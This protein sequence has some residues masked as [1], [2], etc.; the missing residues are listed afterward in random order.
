MII[1]FNY[2]YAFVTNLTMTIIK[3]V[4]TAN[5]IAN[6]TIFLKNDKIIPIIKTTIE[7]IAPDGKFEKNFHIIL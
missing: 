2:I 3:I 4:N 5:Q 6:F 7:A 1:F